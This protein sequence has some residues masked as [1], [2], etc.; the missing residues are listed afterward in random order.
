MIIK[1]KLNEYKLN[2]LWNHRKNYLM[3]LE[4]L[5]LETGRDNVL[6][7]L[8]NHEIVKEVCSNML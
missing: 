7:Y 4:G 8:L 6:T 5:P 2:Y 1:E 3:L